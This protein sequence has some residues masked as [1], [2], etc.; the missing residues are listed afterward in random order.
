ME[1]GNIQMVRNNSL[2]IKNSSLDNSGHFLCSGVNSAGAAIERSQL[3]VFD[4]RDWS[5]ANSSVSSSHMSSYHVTSDMDIAEGRVALMEKT[6]DIQ[7]VYAESS[8]SFRVTWRIIQPHKYIEGYF[9]NYREARPRNVFSSIKVHHARATSYTINRL[10]A[11]TPYEVFIVPFYKSVMGMPSVSVGVNTLEDL[12][13]SAPTIHNVTL[14]GDNVVI[15]WLPLDQRHT[16]GVLEG[17]KILI[18]S[19]IDG[20]ELA[21]LLVSPSESHHSV[22]I[23]NSVQY[24]SISVAL[25]A[26]NKAGVGPFSTPVTLDIDILL[27]E[28]TLINLNTN[29]APGTEATGVWVGALMGSLVLFTVCIGIVI[30]L[31]KRNT[32]KEQGYLSSSTTEEVKEKDETLWIDR[33]WNNSDSQDGSCNSDKKLLKHFEHNNSENEYTYI[34]RGKLA[35]FAS[36]Y[37]MNRSANESNHVGQFH[38]LAPYAS[39]DI[40]RNQIPSLYQVS[41]YPTKKLF[42]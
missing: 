38:D 1:H 19:S 34:D 41:I 14:L 10:K 22:N 4:S 11:N 37:C 42:F 15:Y 7:S 3:L 27:N 20:T 28:G 8:S 17:Y 40:L 33:R 32:A 30:L 5:G 18:T 25:A 13:G 26:V 9:I 16:N 24:P 12:P 21:N 2:V 35:T 31:R 36:E 6:V 23:A 29:L 39:T